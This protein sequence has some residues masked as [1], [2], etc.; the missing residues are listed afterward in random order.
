[1][2]NEYLLK[3]LTGQV[4]TM[5]QNVFMYTNSMVVNLLI[6]A[7][8]GEFAQTFTSEKLRYPPG[9]HAKEPSHLIFP[10]H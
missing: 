4:H 1:V 9:L 6:L 3:G 8:K 5:I 2:Y 7:Y 10:A